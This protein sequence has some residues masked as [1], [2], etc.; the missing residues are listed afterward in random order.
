[1]PIA[2]KD[3]DGVHV[4]LESF[5]AVENPTGEG[6]LDFEVIK[7]SRFEVNGQNESGHLIKIAYFGGGSVFGTRE[8]EPAIRFEASFSVTPDDNRDIRLGF[9]QFVERTERVASY[10]GGVLFYKRSEERLLDCMPARDLEREIASGSQGS[11]LVARSDFGLY[12]F[13]GKS[14][15]A[16]SATETWATDNPNWSAPFKF[17]GREISSLKVADS[18]TTYFAVD[19]GGVFRT[20]ARVKW[21]IDYDYFPFG[22]IDIGNALGFLTIEGVLPVDDELLVDLPVANSLNTLGTHRTS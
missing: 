20:L 12:P 11:A 17:R 9:I 6:E 14:V 22:A 15:R 1:M 13:L 16:A 10:D 7:D 18:F 4:S 19:L 5:T 3:F 8:T 2:E 21:N